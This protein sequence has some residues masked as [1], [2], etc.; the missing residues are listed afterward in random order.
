MYFLNGRKITK[1]NFLKILFQ[2]LERSF[3]AKVSNTKSIAPVGGWPNLLDD[4]GLGYF[5]AGEETSIEFDTSKAGPGF[6][7]TEILTQ[8]GEVKSVAEHTDRR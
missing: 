8:Y 4:K 6:L 3:Q 7:Q 1:K 2:N 5:V